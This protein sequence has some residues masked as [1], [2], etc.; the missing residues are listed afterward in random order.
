MSLAPLVT[1]LHRYFDNQSP[2]PI[3]ARGPGT[4]PESTP[5]PVAALPEWLPHLRN[6]LAQGDNEAREL[7]NSHKT[8]IGTRMPLHLVQQISVA[9][10]NFDFD[11]ALR[12]LPQA[13]AP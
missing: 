9:L 7:W 4:P 1:A 5:E 13:P 2:A 10:A 11:A 6:L 3:G 12:L 8:S